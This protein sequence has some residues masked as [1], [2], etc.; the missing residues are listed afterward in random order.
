MLVPISVDNNNIKKPTVVTK[1]ELPNHQSEEKRTYLKESVKK[2]IN[3]NPFA[4]ADSLLDKVLYSPR[5]K[6]STSN[7]SILAGKNTV[8]SLTDFAETLERKN[9]E[10]SDFFYFT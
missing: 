6:F 1:R 7:F 3:E 9:A 5:I 2:D 10:V 8:V 4:K